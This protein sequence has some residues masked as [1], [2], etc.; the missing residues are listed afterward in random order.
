MRKRSC[1]RFSVPG[2]TLY[3][4]YKSSFLK[5]HEYSYHYFPVLN[6]SKG[7]AN[8]LC[9][10]KFKAGKTLIVK[11]VIP[12]VDQEPEILAN[13]RWISKNHEKSYKYQTGIAF[14]MYGSK[15]DENPVGILTLFESLEKK[16]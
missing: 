6:L 8:F 16:T 7:G 4:K 1:K 14:N 13:V 12:G 10:E 15:K 5:K 2:T 11:I 9:N 3:Y